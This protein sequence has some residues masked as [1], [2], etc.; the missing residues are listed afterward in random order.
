MPAHPLRFHAA[1]VRDPPPGTAR[2]FSP[3]PGKTRWYAS[4]CVRYA[5]PDAYLRGAENPWNTRDYRRRNRR[6]ALYASVFRVTPFYGVFPYRARIPRIPAQAVP[7]NRRNQAEKRGRKGMHHLMHTA[8]IPGPGDAYRV[9]PGPSDAYAP[10]WMKADTITTRTR[11]GRWTTRA[12]PCSSPARRA[13][14]KAR[15]SGTGGASTPIGTS[16]RSPPRG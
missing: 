7:R 13:P 3:I 11:S 1:C 9:P 2:F 5:S 10:A 15:S 14:G 8:R 12:A 4:V 6:Y 16:S